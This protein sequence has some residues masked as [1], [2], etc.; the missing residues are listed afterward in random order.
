[1]AEECEEVLVVK[2]TFLDLNGPNIVERFRR[3]RRA[4][5]E[6]LKRVEPYQPG[7]V[8]DAK[9]LHSERTTVMLRNLPNNYSREMFL[10]MLDQ[11]GLKGLYDFAYLPCDFFH[12][13]NLG[14]AFV[15]MVNDSAVAAIW[16]K[17]D[18]FHDWA[19]PTEKVC[20]VAWSSPHQ[21]LKAHIE[22]YRNSPVMHKRVP[23]S[24]KPVILQNGVRQDFPKPTTVVRPPF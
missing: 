1:M 7:Q 10:H 18:G 3:Q 9:P 22:R 14:Y 5:T 20:R 2:H 4:K 6:V 16:A 21:G 8:A 19:L 11:N 24:F 17:F 13:A 12:G 23:D 15:N